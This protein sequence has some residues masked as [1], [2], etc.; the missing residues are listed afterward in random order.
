M[1]VAV[2]TGADIVFTEVLILVVTVIQQ[3]LQAF[4]QPT[5]VISIILQKVERSYFKG[6]TIYMTKR[7]QGI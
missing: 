1:T 7:A 3:A 5:L 4:Q 2:G 6:Y